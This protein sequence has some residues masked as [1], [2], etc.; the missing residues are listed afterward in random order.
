MAIDSTLLEHQ[1]EDNEL[2]SLLGTLL[3]SIAI[4]KSELKSY[5]L[6]P[7]SSRSA[8][9]LEYVPLPLT[10]YAFVLTASHR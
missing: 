3:S 5:G 10:Y 6:P 4:Y 7:P 1:H 9:P 2:D 8:H